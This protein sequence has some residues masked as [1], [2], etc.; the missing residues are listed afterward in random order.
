MLFRED[1]FVARIFKFFLKN[2]LEKSLPGCRAAPT[3]C[4][5][6]ARPRRRHKPRSQRGGAA[7]PT[8]RDRRGGGGRRAAAWPCVCVGRGDRVHRCIQD[9]KRRQID[10]RE[11]PRLCRASQA[12]YQEARWRCRDPS[13]AE[14]HPK[15]P[16]RKRHKPIAESRAAGAAPQQPGARARCRRGG[17]WSSILRGHNRHAAPLMTRADHCRARDLCFR[18]ATVTVQRPSFDAIRKRSKIL[19][20]HYS[21]EPHNPAASLPNVQT[22]RNHALWT[23]NRDPARHSPNRPPGRAPVLTGV[24]PP[25]HRPCCAGLALRDWIGATLRLP[26]PPALWRSAVL[27]TFHT[28]GSNFSK[29]VCTI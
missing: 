13:F 26:V 16:W 25:I 2:N 9:S 10:C 27:S 12:D 8:P 7:A 4:P 24:L 5:E 28:I 20:L 29:I 1:F 22:A 11:A 17:S 14:R 3:P 19:E 21:A 23:Q 6:H 18:R 15:L